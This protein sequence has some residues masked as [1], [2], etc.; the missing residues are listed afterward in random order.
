MRVVCVCARWA[1][2]GVNETARQHSFRLI[3]QM[4][5]TL[6]HGRARD[7]CPLGWEGST[8]L[9]RLCA[10]ITAGSHDEW[11]PGGPAEQVAR[12]Q[13]L[14]AHSCSGPETASH[15]PTRTMES[16]TSGTGLADCWALTKNVR[17]GCAWGTVLT[18]P[19]RNLSTA[20]CNAHGGVVALCG[21]ER[22]RQ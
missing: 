13:I 10:W 19:A 21:A 20:R 5:E 15:R 16:V 14:E 12:S 18:S 4:M 22:P 9:A 8:S 6:G 3:A 2:L 17:G 7:K 1:R 11:R